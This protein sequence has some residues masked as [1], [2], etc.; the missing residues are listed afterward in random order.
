MRGPEPPP[1]SK[2]KGKGYGEGKGKGYGEG[3]GKGYGE[4]KGKSYSKGK[5]EGYGKGKGEDYGKGKGK[6]SGLGKGSSPGKGSAPGKGS[7]PGHG[8]M[9]KGTK[10]SDANEYSREQWGCFSCGAFNISWKTLC[11]YCGSARPPPGPETD[12]RH[13]VPQERV[14]SLEAFKEN[15]T[16]KDKARLFS[17]YIQSLRTLRLHD[18]P[19]DYN[20][21]ELRAHLAELGPQA[22]SAIWVPMGDDGARSFF[23]VRFRTTELAERAAAI[24]PPMY[25]GRRLQFR[26]HQDRESAGAL[27]KRAR[28]VLEGVADLDALRGDSTKKLRPASWALNHL[29]NNPIPKAFLQALKYDAHDGDALAVYQAFYKEHSLSVLP[30]PVEPVIRWEEI[31]FGEEINAVMRQYPQ[32]TAIQSLAWPVLLAGRDCIGIAETGSGKTLAFVLPAVV[33]LRAQSQTRPKEGPLVLI[34]GPVRELVVQIAQEAARFKGAGFTVGEVS[35]GHGLQGRLGQAETILGGVDVLVATPKRLTTFVECRVVSLNRVTFF[36]LDE[37]DRMLDMGFDPQIR[38]L[39]SQLRPDRQM[40]MF[41]A[42]WDAK[43]HAMAQ[44]YLKHNVAQIVARSGTGDTAMANPNVEQRFVFNTTDFDRNEEIQRVIQGLKTELAASPCTRILIFCSRTTVVDEVATALS[45]SWKNVYSLH[46][47]LEQGPRESNL[48]QFLDD[49]HAIL[50]ATDLAGRGL[51]IKG[52]PC[53]VNVQ[54]PV[55]LLQY[56]HRIGR[57]GRA[58]AKGV[59]VTFLEAHDRPLAPGLIKILEDVGQP[60][61]TGLTD[62]RDRSH[63]FYSCDRQSTSLFGHGIF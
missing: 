50:V 23:S 19:E 63:L 51:D 45:K 44:N 47:D 13:A 41:T 31:D 36:V 22:F 46:A 25:G 29:R 43:T 55:D 62:L 14:A 49:P 1:P 60:I 32:P 40:S 10:T 3:K 35:G 48:R 6:G 37:A 26:S 30:Q 33:H 54:M 61:P 56:I 4:G 38:D 21:G 9:G 8:G 53:V 34:L 57:T 18:A 20:M 42:T 28:E 24:G 27:L 5:G 39:A 7:V 59:A 16:E 15:I 2:G 12:W 11:D 17:R 58:G 52:M